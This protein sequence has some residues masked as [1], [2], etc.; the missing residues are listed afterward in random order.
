MIDQSYLLLSASCWFV[1]Y[2]DSTCPFLLTGVW[3]SRSKLDAIADQG[4]AAVRVSIAEPY[5]L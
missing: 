3:R 5:A 1:Q 4:S 2:I